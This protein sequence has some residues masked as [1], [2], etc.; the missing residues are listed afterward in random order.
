M[1]LTEKGFPTF[2][3]ADREELVRCHFLAKLRDPLCSYLN[4]AEVKSSRTPMERFNS[5]LEGP[6][7]AGSTCTAATKTVG[8]GETAVQEQELQSNNPGKL[9]PLC[10]LSQGDAGEG[11][12]QKSCRQ[13]STRKV[14]TRWHRNSLAEGNW[15]K[16][17]S[18]RILPRV[19]RCS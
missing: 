10:L 18:R 5:L 2:G 1:E 7:N 17:K 16:R 13:T 19:K 4:M 3:R 9:R 12:S 8:E 14:G 6:A 15:T 11:A